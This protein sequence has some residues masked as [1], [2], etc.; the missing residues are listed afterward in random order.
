MNGIEYYIGIDFGAGE[1]SASYYDINGNQSADSGEKLHRLCFDK[2][3][4]VP[5]IPS[6]I[7]EIRGEWQLVFNP[8]DLKCS[9]LR[10]NFK[11]KVREMRPAQIEENKTFWRLVFSAIINSNSFLY[12]N[13]HTK[14]RN[15]LLSVACP[16][17]WSEDEASEYLALILNAGLPVDSITK[18]SDAALIKWK[19]YGKEG[20]TLVIDCGSSTID[21]TLVCAGERYRGL[22]YNCIPPQG[23]QQVE[24]LLFN[25]FKKS[26]DFQSAYRDVIDFLI[27]K[28]SRINL[29]DAIRLCLRHTKETFYTYEPEEVLFELKKHPFTNGPGYILD[30]YL[31]SDEFKRIVSPY[32]NELREFFINV[33][34]TLELSKVMPTSIILSGG[35]SR[36][37]LIKKMLSSVFNL[38]AIFLDHEP[39]MVVADGL[40]LN[41]VLEGTKAK[42]IGLVNSS[43]RNDTT[44]PF[45]H[46]D[47]IPSPQD[48]ID[49]FFIDTLNFI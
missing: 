38:E 46:F 43:C 32:F 11:K 4:C 24:E 49:Q 28:K 12:Y 1:T 5:I 26:D 48:A 42:D 6:A 15:F 23:A 47:D 7:R 39:S 36:M 2:A 22:M 18:E 40:A 29:D 33:H 21:L 16:S 25:H 34:D 19:K 41:T 14:E 44:K 45:Y 3:G 9:D 13:E 37:P 10:I 20:N 35:A 31:T 27:E 30:E 8:T 17:S